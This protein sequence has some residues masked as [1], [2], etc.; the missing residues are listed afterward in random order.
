MFNKR[1][2][3][4]ANAT[5][6]LGSHDQA[7]REVSDRPSLPGRREVLKAGA[8]MAVA[9]LF[10]GDALA[11]QSMSNQPRRSSVATTA[12]NAREQHM[13][14]Q[15]VGSKPSVK[16]PSDW[17]TGTVRIDPMFDAKGPSRV[18]SANVT[19][20]PG[21]RTAWHTHPLG[22]HIIITSGVGWVQQEGGAVQEVRPGDVVWFPPNVKH[23]HG[24]SPEN[25]MTHIAIQEAK[26]G[27]AV[28]WMEH[29]TDAQYK[30]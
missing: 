5:S 25:A 24:A 15:R 6:A 3:P 4:T 21:A 9:S 17:F 22:Q 29:V 12:R 26:D 10:L 16:G 30:R 14:I 23:W 7:L 27:S 8:G 1:A 18:G 20:E 19:F 13:D 2:Y 28:E 11:A